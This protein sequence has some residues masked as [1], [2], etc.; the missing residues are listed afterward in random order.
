MERGDG[1]EGDLKNKAGYLYVLWLLY[2]L[3]GIIGNKS[4]HR[5][6]SQELYLENSEVMNRVNNGGKSCSQDGRLIEE[7]CRT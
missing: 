5:Y 4:S 7:E 6:H 3:E 1:Q 2:F